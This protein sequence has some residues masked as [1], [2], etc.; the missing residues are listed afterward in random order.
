AM[1]RSRVVV[2]TAYGGPEVLQ[3][4]EQEVSD[5]GS[6]EVLLAVRAAGVN[7]VDWKMYSGTRGSDASALPMRLGMEASGVVAAVGPDAVGP[8][9]PLAVGDE[10]I[11]YRI[12][13]AY[14]E[15]VVVPAAAAVPKPPEVS[16]EL[17]G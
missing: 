8:A 14:A 15:R 7:P 1:E 5:P 4:V 3:V 6:D 12:A 17:A 11:A 9:G 2:A 10:V 16:F 13:G